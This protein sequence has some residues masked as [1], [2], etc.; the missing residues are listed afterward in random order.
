MIQESTLEP[1]N[2]NAC[3]LQSANVSSNYTQQICILQTK[4]AVTQWLYSVKVAFENDVEIE[5]QTQKLWYC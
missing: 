2:T 1:L 3:A 4:Y 5:F